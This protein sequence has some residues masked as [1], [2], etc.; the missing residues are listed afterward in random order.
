MSSRVSLRTLR[1]LSSIPID[2]E[3]GACADDVRCDCAMTAD[4]A[5]GVCVGAADCTTVDGGTLIEFG[6]LTD[7]VDTAVPLGAGR[8]CNITIAVIADAATAATSGSHALRSHEVGVVCTAPAAVFRG[9]MPSVANN[10]SV[11]SA[12]GV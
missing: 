5:V 9:A 1:S 10:W 8:S 3:C 6:R 11:T 4:D 2:A 12:G 7:P